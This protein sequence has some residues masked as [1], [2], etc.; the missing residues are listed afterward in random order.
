MANLEL[1]I[2]ARCG[3]WVVPVTLTSGA[4]SAL[5]TPIKT[6]KTG[7]VSPTYAKSATA[8]SNEKV[9]VQFGNGVT[10]QAPKVTKAV[11]ISDGAEATSGSGGDVDKLTIEVSESEKWFVTNIVPLR[12]KTVII[13][14]P[15]GE[16]S[17]AGN[18]GFFFLMGTLTSD[19]PLA[20]EPEKVL[21]VAL[22]WSGVTATLAAGGI[23][24]IDALNLVAVTQPGGVTLDPP[25]LETGDAVILAGG[26]L[27]WKD[28]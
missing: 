3:M 13:C 12:G 11:N 14:G 17:E 10:A 8:S 20:S 7:K 25:T 21:T 1:T 16:N 26:N 23:T 19:I 6:P 15:S 5:G 18:Q 24:A 4:I 27:M 2:R 9:T 28:E 22:E